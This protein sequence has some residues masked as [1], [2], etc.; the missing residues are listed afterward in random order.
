MDQEG[1]DRAVALQTAGRLLEAIEAF[2]SLAGESDDA[3]LKSGLMLNEVRCYTILGRVTDAE[4]VL[5]QIR[6]LA[7]DDDE[8]RINVD[9]VGACV[10]TQGGQHEKAL[11]QFERVLAE[12]VDYLNA[13][14]NRDFYEDIQRRRA[15]CL[16][17]V[18]R[19]GEALPILEEASAF[20][21]LKP[22]DQQQIHLYLGVCY[23]ELREDRLA[24]E[25][26]LRALEFGLKNGFEAEARFRVAVLYF[27][28]GGFAQAKYQLES[29]L[30]VYPQEIPRVPRKFVYQQLSR[31]Y[32]YLGEKENADRY[33]KLAADCPL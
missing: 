22:E 28:D 12:Y 30:Q 10:A 16:I 4:H 13:P 20:R 1:I 2:H 31:V 19:Y 17:H 25:E 14:D 7:P 11:R 33:K 18:R 23:A 24:K 15:L 6:A 27:L 5:G 3:N 21:T 32:H 9:Y 8:V 26:L 29:I